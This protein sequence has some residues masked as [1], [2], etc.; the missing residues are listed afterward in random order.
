M[1]INFDMEDLDYKNGIIWGPS[2]I[3]S[4]RIP[5]NI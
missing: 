1:G 5:N 3:G 4:L 2:A